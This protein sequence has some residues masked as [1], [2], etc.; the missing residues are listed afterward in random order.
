MRP[1]E[2]ST[3]VERGSISVSFYPRSQRGPP[4]QQFPMQT[5]LA[6][7]VAIRGVPLANTGPGH[8][9]LS[10]ENS[11]LT[12]TGLLMCQENTRLGLLAG[13]GTLGLISNDLPSGAKVWNATWRNLSSK[14]LVCDC[15]SCRYCTIWN[16]FTFSESLMTQAAEGRA[17]PTVQLH[18][19]PSPYLRYAHYTE[20]NQLILT[21]E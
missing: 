16:P 14:K 2:E 21:E 17:R 9:G 11:P 19:L 6:L 7:F 18:Y 5:V 3:F 4:W 12:S 15:V 8:T 13:R 10:Q 1:T 20:P